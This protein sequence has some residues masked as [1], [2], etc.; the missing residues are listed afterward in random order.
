MARASISLPVPVSPVSSTESGVGGDAP[1]DRQELR[2]P[3][4]RPRCSRDRRRAPRPATARRAASRRGGSGRASTAV[5]T[6]LRIA[7][8]VQRSSSAGARPR[9]ELPGLVAVDADRH[10]IVGRRRPG[11]RQRL[12]LVQ[13]SALDDAVRPLPPV[14]TSAT[15]SSAAGVLH[16]RERLAAEDVRVPGELEERDRAVEVGG[17]VGIRTGIRND[18]G[19]GRFSRSVEITSA[20]EKPGSSSR[21]SSGAHCMSPL[22]EELKPISRCRHAI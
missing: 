14:A 18:A 3:A 22:Q 19:L 16:E 21:M 7:A 8:R 11:R 6:S 4:R 9:E 13:P 20:L 17:G 5:A 15:L 2:R 12:R 10:E 1:G